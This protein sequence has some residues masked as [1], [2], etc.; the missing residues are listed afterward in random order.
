LNNISIT[1]ITSIL[2]Y[3]HLYRT[4][5][6]VPLNAHIVPREHF[7]AD[8]SYAKVTA[9]YILIVITGYSLS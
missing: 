3:N 1:N 7:P 2:A 4:Y 8:V 6:I 9:V 5:I